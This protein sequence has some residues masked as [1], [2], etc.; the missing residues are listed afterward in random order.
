VGEIDP[1]AVRRAASTI[2]SVA[3]TVRAQIPDEVG[4]VAGALAGSASAAAGSSL[5][6]A[7]TDSY[8]RGA[9]SA[10]AHAQ[11]M[12]ASADAWATTD[13][14]VVDKFSQRLGGAMRAV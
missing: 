12:R 2:E 9:T 4:Q 11:S 13:Q 1:G 7:W 3:R 14:A 8:T 5:A 6:A 10:D